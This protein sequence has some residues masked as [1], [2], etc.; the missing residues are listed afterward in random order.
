M[1]VFGGPLFVVNQ[2]ICFSKFNPQ[3]LHVAYFTES[4][5]EVPCHADL[6][7]Q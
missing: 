6:S 3:R 2:A 7:A 1:T 5:L 4:Q